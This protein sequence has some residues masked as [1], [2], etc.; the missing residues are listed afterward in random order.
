M[1]IFLIQN[2]GNVVKDRVAVIYS[3]LV[4]EKSNLWVGAVVTISNYWICT[5]HTDLTC[6]P[7]RKCMILLSSQAGGFQS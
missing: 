2:A 5:F 7:L 1:S 3:V 4:V 6:P